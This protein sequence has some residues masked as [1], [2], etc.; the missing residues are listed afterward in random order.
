VPGDENVK[1]SNRSF[2]LPKS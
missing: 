1:P 2:R